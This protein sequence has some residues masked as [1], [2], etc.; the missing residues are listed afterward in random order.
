VIFMSIMVGAQLSD[1]PVIVRWSYNHAFD[2]STPAFR[3]AP[4]ELLA[5]RNCSTIRV[6]KIKCIVKIGI[7]RRRIGGFDSK[8]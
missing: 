4:G 3:H 2:K 7:G 6:P 1:A 8:L 5:P